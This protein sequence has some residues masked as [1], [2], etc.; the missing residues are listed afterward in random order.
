MACI[1]QIKN[2]VNGKL[3]IGSTIRPAYIRKYEHFSKLR[4]NLHGNDH[5]QKSFN[6]YGENNFTFSVVEEYKF[7]EDYSK[8][9]KVEYLLGREYF[10]IEKFNPEYNIKTSLT[11]GN[12]GYKHSEETRKK[13]GESNISKNPSKRT[14]RKRELLEM[15]Q[16]GEFV[17]KGKKPGWKHSPEAIQKIKER[18]NQEDNKLRIRELQKL[19]AAK[20]V[21]SHQSEESKKKM[22]MTKFKKH[23]EIEIYSKEGELLHVCN[24]SPEASQITGVKRSAISNNLAGYSKSAGNL[25]F[26]YKIY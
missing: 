9:Y 13:I 22:L 6:K 23:R 7:P 18:S 12:T 25:I 14:I 1:Y 8:I 26:K 20:R 15:K 19:S 5:L 4:E 17:Q 10:F 16:R 11:T 21:G 2:E 3:Y 24:F